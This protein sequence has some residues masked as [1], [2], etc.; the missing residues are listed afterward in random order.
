MFDKLIELLQATYEWFIPFVVVLEYQ[1]GVVLRFGKHKKD[2]GPG[3]HWIIPFGVDN[4]ITHSV[5]P[6]VHRLSPQ[7]LSTADDHACVFQVV[8]TWKVHDI[9]KMLLEVEDAPTALSDSVYGIVAQ[10]VR[11]LT[12]DELSKDGAL[13]PAYKKIRARAFV[14]GIEVKQISFSDV[15]RCKSLRIWQEQPKAGE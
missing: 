11:K 8:V 13:E 12:W 2:I 15:Q 7:S 1:R 14:W 3:F 6:C 4:A 5:V 9:R 10:H